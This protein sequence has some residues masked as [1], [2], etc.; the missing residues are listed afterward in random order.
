MYNI[1]LESVFPESE[2]HQL[3]IFHSL[4]DSPLNLLQIDSTQGLK[5]N[6]SAD[7]SSMAT[8]F[9]SAWGKGK[10]KEEQ[11]GIRTS[12]GCFLI[13][14]WMLFSSFHGTKSHP[15]SPPPMAGQPRGSFQRPLLTCLLEGPCCV[16][17]HIPKPETGRVG[18]VYVSRGKMKT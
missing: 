16:T 1:L 9:W 15:N 3:P 5:I 18:L 10:G 17:L 13:T 2:Q 12:I 4:D 11:T 8:W 14:A 7:K 6:S